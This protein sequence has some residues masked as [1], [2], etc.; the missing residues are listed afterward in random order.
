MSSF[1]STLVVLILVQLRISDLGLG[2]L[3]S[4]L[5]VPFPVPASENEV[6]RDHSLF[7]AQ[8]AVTELR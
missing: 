1:I 7:S 8:R 2:S 4:S 3:G 6:P 5:P